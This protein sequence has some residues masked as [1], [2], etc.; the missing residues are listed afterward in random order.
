[1]VNLYGR[2]A[3]SQIMQKQLDLLVDTLANLLE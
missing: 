1:L 2:N 3:E